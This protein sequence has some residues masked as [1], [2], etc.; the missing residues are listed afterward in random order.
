M[1]R[2]GFDLILLGDPTS[3]KNTQ[4]DLLMR[5]YD[6]KAVES[7]KQWRIMVKKNDF[8]GKW[9]RRT[10]SKGRPTP[11]AIVKWFL[12]NKVASAVKGKDLIFIG[13]PRLKPEAQF[14]VGIFNKKKRDFLALYL[15][16]PEKEIYLRAGR[17]R[18]Q[19][20]ERKI[21]EKRI[22]WHKTQVSKTVKYFQKLNK[23]K[24]ID[25]KQPIAKVSKDIQKAINDYQRS[26]RN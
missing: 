10:F 1:K 23:L 11:V 6:F 22:G 13:T 9:L 16:L 18:V 17:R 20:D 19:E 8:Y 4:A 26:K 3:G 24:F 25:G 21:T 5:K 12:K 15:K 2:L 7:G 14:L